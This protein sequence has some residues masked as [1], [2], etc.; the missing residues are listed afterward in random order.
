MRCSSASGA[1][2]MLQSE[3]QRQRVTTLPEV[4]WPSPV[5][6]LLDQERRRSLLAEPGSRET[7]YYM[8]LTWWPPTAEHAAR[9]AA[10]GRRR[11][12]RGRPAGR[13]G[14]DGLTQEQ[15]LSLRNLCGRPTIS[16]TCS[17]AC[18]RA[19][20]R[21][22]LTKRRP[23]CTTVSRIAGIRWGRWPFTRTSTRNSVIRPLVGG[24]YPQLGDWHLR[25][26]SIMGYPAQVR[27]GHRAASRCRQPRLSLVYALGGTREAGA[28]G[29]AAQD[30]GRLDGAGEVAHGAHGRKHVQSAAAHP[31]HG[32][33]EQGRG[34][35]CGP[36]G[37][38]RGH[39]GLWRVHQYRHGLGSGPRPGRNEAA[40]RHADAR[41]SGLY[42]HGRAAACHGG[43]ALQSARQPP[44]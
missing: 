34:S 30:A 41:Q 18:W 16:W 29:A 31:Q 12:A 36:A 5:L 11:A 27:R 14:D 33:H 19:V 40:P 2:W 39:R 32:C 37:S 42:G 9:A 23:I 4:R 25:T 7:R 1:A 10:P 21:S 26:C 24:W 15:R 3:A 35:G 6:T 8:T 20:A 38:R 43:L 17:R 28:G 13:R 44:R 22:P